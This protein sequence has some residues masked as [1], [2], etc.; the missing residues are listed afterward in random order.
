MRGICRSNPAALEWTEDLVQNESLTAAAAACAHE[1]KAKQYEAW[2]ATF[3]L[4][5]L[6]DHRDRVEYVV[7]VA[8]AD[9][10][11]V[12]LLLH[13]LHENLRYFSQT[14]HLLPQAVLTASPDGTFDYASRRWYQITGTPADDMLH[15]GASLK[16]AA[17][18]YAP[19]FETYWSKGVASGEVF[20]FE[21]PLRTVRGRRWFEFRAAPSYEGSRLR[22]WIVTVDDIQERVEAR[23]EVARARTR[24]SALADI[25]AIALDNS[26][27]DDALV[28]PAL[29]RA[30]SALDAIWSVVLTIDGE[31]T[32]C[33]YPARA[34][35]PTDDDARPVLRFPLQVGEGGEQELTV[36]RAPGSEPF[37]QYD[38][39]FVRD[40]AW[41]IAS[42]VRN[43]TSYR[44][45]SRIARVL[46]TAML[47]VALPRAPG[48]FFD[49]SYITAE[50]DT[51]VGGDWYDAFELNDGRIACSIGDVAGHGL[52][53]AVV[54]GHVREMVRALAM[55]GES[56]SE[57]LSET[58]GVVLA[59]GYGLITAIV[60]YIDPDT[61]V[62]EYASAGHAPPLHVQAD[63]TVEALELGDVILGA[64]PRARFATHS[65]RLRGECALVMYT[66]GL[67]EYA[68]DA[69][70]GEALLCSSLSQWAREGF[71]SPADELV[72]QILGGANQ[73]DDAAMLIVRAQRSA[74]SDYVNERRMLARS[75]PD[76]RS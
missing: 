10:A 46:Q 76:S 32:V 26:L 12:P 23:T 4:I 72:H 54:M 58:N 42:A 3:L 14:I 13:E 38:I 59:G 31:R 2:G 67:V 25:G 56:P 52:N 11:D 29:Q 27:R 6:I 49:V 60:A 36:I 30:A 50:T 7:G 70:T 57:V 64:V 73:N 51:L 22:K 18:V 5:P 40:V 55:R 16:R 9:F 75:A 53:A 21:L 48:V 1:R 74:L 37:D 35:L 15:V 24:L 28:Q 19:T 17:G 34:V 69:L 71:R 41:R 66:D 47:P 8:G 63:G 62:V 61:L 43:A 68:H 44:R 39:D 65:L 45:E 33:T 20:A